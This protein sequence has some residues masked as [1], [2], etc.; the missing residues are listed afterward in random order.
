MFDLDNWQEIFETIRKNKLRTF[1]TGFSVA[2]GIFMLIIL[3]GFG[4]GLQNGVNQEF[5][6]SATNAIWFWRGQTSMPYKGMKPGRYIRMNNE[7]YEQTKLKVDGVEY[8]S[9]RFNIWSGNTRVN[10]KNEYG[11]FNVQ[12][13]HP[14]Y[15]FIEKVEMLEGRYINKTDIDESRKVVMISQLAVESLFKAEDPMGKYIN[16]N[17][18]PF[19]VVGLYT[20]QD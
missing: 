16:I 19:K 11:D 18:V 4:S 2:W 10:Y 7:D 1:L 9:G 14:D 5:E 8:I 6:S 15:K 17:N 3:L 13:A 12:S 20:D